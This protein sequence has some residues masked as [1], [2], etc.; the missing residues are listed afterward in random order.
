MGSKV[1][2]LV[3]LL[4][5]TGGA[6]AYNYQRN[7]AA[8]KVE[9]GP[10]PFKGYSDGDLTALAEAYGM[11]IEQYEQLVEAARQRKA[12][13][14][15]NGALGQRLRDF[16]R[17]QANSGQQRAMRGELIDRQVKLAEIEKEQGLRAPVADPLA[18]HM[19]RL[20]TI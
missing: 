5:V 10:R 20:L 12:G 9:E 18:I 7:V 1:L 4:A 6:G 14:R 2:L 3:I 13:V 16:E 8:E 17:V 15:Q 19:K 11:E